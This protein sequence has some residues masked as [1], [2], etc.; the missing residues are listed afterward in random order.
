MKAGE[1]LTLY[2]ADNQP[3]SLPYTAQI[4]SLS[5]T[6]TSTST[7]RNGIQPAAVGDGDGIPPVEVC[8]RGLLTLNAEI[9]A[10]MFLLPYCTLERCWP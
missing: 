4:T 3:V 9:K 10:L 1:K 6:S 8:V 2:G 7:L 5:L